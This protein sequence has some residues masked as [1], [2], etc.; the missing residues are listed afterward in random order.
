MSNLVIITIQRALI[1]RRTDTT[2]DN[3][4]KANLRFHTRT[5]A[6]HTFN[7]IILGRPIKEKTEAEMQTGT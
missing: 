6:V 2:T 3:N 1:L 5:Q 7:S 4:H